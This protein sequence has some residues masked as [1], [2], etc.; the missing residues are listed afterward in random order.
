MIN[1]SNKILNFIEQGIYSTYAIESFKKHI[2]KN[3]TQLLRESFEILKDLLKKYDKTEYYSKIIYNTIQFIKIICENQKFSDEEIEINKKRIKKSRKLI[4]PYS[5]T[6]NLMLES[7]NLLDEIVLEENV[8]PKSL[9]KLIK[10]LINNFEDVNIIKK[11]ININKII[12]TK[13]VE[14]FDYVFNKALDAIEN[15][16]RDIYYYITLLKIV[17]NVRINKNKYI[18][19][20]LMCKKNKFS[21]EIKNIIYGLRRPYSA[22]EILEKYNIIKSE[23]YQIITPPSNKT[24]CSNIITI[25]RQKTFAREDA[26]SIKKYGNN[27]HIGIY[28]TDAGYEI[29]P[30][31]DVNYNALNNFRSIYLPKNKIS[32]LNPEIEKS[33]SLNKNKFRRVI[34]LSVIMNDSGD[35]KDFDISKEIIKVNENLTYSQADLI[36]NY[37]P[38]NELY[39]FLNDLFIISKILSNKYKEN[40]ENLNF[41]FEKQQ[42]NSE[43]IISKFMILYNRILALIAKDSN[44]P[45]IYISQEKEYITALMNELNIEINKKTKN[46]LSSLYLDTKYTIYPQAYAGLGFEYYSHSSNPARQYP[47]LYNQYLL[48]QFLF[49]DITRFHND[50]NFEELINYMNKRNREL[51]LMEAEYKRALELKNS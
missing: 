42:P 27:Y 38:N 20:L 21:N 29:D 15:D 28:V 23:S 41:N 50:E 8:D 1:N 37:L 25:D 49:K 26:I 48:H 5:K 33:L 40:T 24:I 46:L 17:Y 10:I 35:I 12:V 34:M 39:T 22:E 44:I 16:N 14:L 2:N 31:S 3:N 32:M 9:T 11:F 6:N 7:T 19:K 47:D 18:S 4:L 13:Y 43:D 36:L 30:Y 45:Y 51:Y